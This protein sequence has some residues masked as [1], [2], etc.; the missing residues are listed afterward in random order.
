MATEPSVAAVVADGRR[1]VND[2]HPAGSQRLDEP[3]QLAPRGP[4]ERARRLDLHLH[5]ARRLRQPQAHTAGE[6]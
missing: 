3:G 5:P 6:G 4:G 1:D 2:A